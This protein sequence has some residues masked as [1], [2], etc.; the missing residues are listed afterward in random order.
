MK[1]QIGIWLDKKQAFLI[2][3][4]NGEESVKTIISNVESY[5][6]VGGARSKTPYGP[7]DVVSEKKSLERQKHQLSQYFQQILTTVKD[8]D[9]LY[10]FGP[11]DTKLKL[12]DVINKNKS[13]KFVVRKTE[14]A[15]SMT[16]GQ[17]IAQARQ[18]F[19]LELA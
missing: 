17:M 16:E 6:V 18:A 3:F 1:I 11:A 13:L 19:G 14:T 12:L 5:H 4:L 10:L 15:D 8:A 7:M 9:E 2:A